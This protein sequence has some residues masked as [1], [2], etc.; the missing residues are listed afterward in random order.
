MSTTLAE[1][2]QQPPWFNGRKKVVVAMSAISLVLLVVSAW[3]YVYS[4]DDL[5]TPSLPIS[6]P[7][8][9]S[10]EMPK[11]KHEQVSTKGTTLVSSLSKNRFMVAI[12]T[13]NFAIAVLAVIAA[14]ILAVYYVQAKNEAIV[15][16]KVLELESQI[17]ESQQN[18]VSF[19]ERAKAAN[20]EELEKE[21]KSYFEVALEWIQNQTWVTWTII[22]SVSG[23]VMVIMTIIRAWK[24][25][26]LFGPS[27]P[28]KI[29][30]YVVHTIFVSPVYLLSLLDKFLR[31]VKKNTDEFGSATLRTAFYILFAII[32][33]PFCL[34]SWILHFLGFNDKFKT[35]LESM[36][37]KW[38]K[39]WEKLEFFEKQFSVLEGSDI[40]SLTPTAGST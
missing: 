25:P 4:Q 5:S 19:S 22:G 7:S 11:S 6:T 21:A 8:E 3:V 14:I 37:L 2:Q 23:V 30:C 39:G 15:T 24:D 35:H 13:V 18:L 38:Y 36:I 28:S 20:I 9:I 34:F 31:W 16:A 17:K 12:L 27:V 32:A 33:F 1:Q 40:S 26:D 10:L 29:C